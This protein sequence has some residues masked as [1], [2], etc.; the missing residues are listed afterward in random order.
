MAGFGRSQGVKA[1]YVAHRHLADPE[2][3]AT[4][5][6]V[7][8]GRITNQYS[9]AAREH[10]Q[11]YYGLVRH[12]TTDVKRIAANTGF[13]EKEIARIKSF[14]FLEKHDL[15]QGK[16]QYFDP[17]FAMAQSWQRL[18]NGTP[19]PHDITLLK[20]EIMEN[21]LM[22]EGLTQEQ[23]HKE[24]SKKYNYPRESDEYYAALEEYHREKKTWPRL[25]ILLRKAIGGDI[26]QSILKVKK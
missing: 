5:K 18:I 1:Q 21:R 10:A 22:H 3:F 19:E 24:A 12:M 14:V 4:I 23:A 9:K 16:L 15:G 7:S 20:H 11:K 26:F 25:I 2:N 13:P 17:D 6:L 8:G